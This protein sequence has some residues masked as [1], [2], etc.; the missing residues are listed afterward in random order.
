[1]KYLFNIHTKYLVYNLSVDQLPVYGLFPSNII[2]IHFEV[3]PF[4][5]LPT[6]LMRT[7]VHTVH[8]AGTASQV[9][10]LSKIA[11]NSKGITLATRNS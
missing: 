6:C 1:M 4:P 9:K 3:Y 10:N 11:T 7:H 2:S 8:G 5:V